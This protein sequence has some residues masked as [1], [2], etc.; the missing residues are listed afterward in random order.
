MRN[1]NGKEIWFGE[2]V[3]HKSLGEGIFVDYDLHDGEVVVEFTDELG[4]KD[5]LRV[6]DCMLSKVETE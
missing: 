2:V 6:S 4:Y 1:Y 5:E 3:I